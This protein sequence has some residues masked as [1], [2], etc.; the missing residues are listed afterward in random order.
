MLGIIMFFQLV[1][2][3][4]VMNLSGANMQSG[5]KNNEQVP[6]QDDANIVL[7]QGKPEL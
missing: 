2:A 3:Y 6:V 1:L 5:I 7:P 4:Q